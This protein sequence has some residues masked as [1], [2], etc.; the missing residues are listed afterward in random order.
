MLSS[1]AATSDGLKQMGNASTD[2][3]AGSLDGKV[4]V[5]GKK[6]NKQKL[7]VS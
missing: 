6:K 3:I 5:R 7:H 1:M 4:S 2:N